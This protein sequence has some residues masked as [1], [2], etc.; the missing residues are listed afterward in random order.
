MPSKLPCRS[1]LIYFQVR[2]RN[3]NGMGG[4]CVSIAWIAPSVSVSVLII[5]TYFVLSKSTTSWSEEVLLVANIPRDVGY[6]YVIRNRSSM[7][8][9]NTIANKSGSHTFNFFIRSTLILNSSNYGR[10]S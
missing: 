2:G 4:R 5:S 1:S 10:S 8:A 3:K 6:F 7:P 9:I